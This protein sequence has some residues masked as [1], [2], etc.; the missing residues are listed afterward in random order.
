MTSKGTDVTQC[1]AILGAG[2]FAREMYWH[3][4]ETIPWARLAFIDDVTDTSEVNMAGEIV[5]VVKNWRFDAVPTQGT[6]SAFKEFVLGVGDPRVKK[7][8]AEKAL[9]SGLKPAPT[10]VHP[11]AHIQGRDCR[12][13]VGGI[14]A[15][16]CIL[17]T[18]VTIGDFVLLNLSTTVGH[19]AVIGDYVTCN[20]GCQISG[21]VTIGE[22]ASLGTGTVVRERT[23][24]AAGVVTGAQACIVKDIL[25]PN[26]TVVGVP[27]KKLG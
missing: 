8:L 4:R 19:D 1:I 16:G 9:Q 13:G 27:A 26:I 14:I 11:R 2:G 5:P 25:E 15:P 17:T 7:L 12:I 10:I 22:G 18:N 3:I 23:A 20:P 6:V 24:I 21:G